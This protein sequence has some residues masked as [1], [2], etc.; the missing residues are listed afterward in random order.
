MANKYPQFSKAKKEFHRSMAK[1]RGKARSCI[2][3]KGYK[4]P[5]E[6]QAMGI[7]RDF[8]FR[9]YHCPTCLMYH[10]TSKDPDTNTDKEQAA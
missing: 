5:E 3:K 7:K 2:R 9:V 8:A 4:S 10:L 1:L 6:A